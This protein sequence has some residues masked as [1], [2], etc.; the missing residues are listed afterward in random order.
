DSV[1][2]DQCLD[3]RGYL[4][5]PGTHV[6]RNVH[7]NTTDT[8]CVNP[9]LNLTFGPYPTNVIYTSRQS[10]GRDTFMVD[11]LTDMRVPTLYTS[12]SHHRDPQRYDPDTS[13]PIHGDRLSGGH[14]S[15]VESMSPR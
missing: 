15:K 14:W 9:A 4:Q 7:K 2:N 1:T 12:P 8:A 5:C 6:D 3:L 13:T 10:T 11:R